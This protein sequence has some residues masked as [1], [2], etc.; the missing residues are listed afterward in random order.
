M[1][2]RI[3]VVLADETLAV[4]D[5][6]APRGSRSRLIDDAVRQYVESRGRKNL[7][8][9]LKEGYLANARL[10]L[11]LAQEWFPLEEEAWQTAFGRKKSR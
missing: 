11:E 4:L 8:R 1:S 10:N 5:R 2:K 6:V 9:R 7:R 3:N